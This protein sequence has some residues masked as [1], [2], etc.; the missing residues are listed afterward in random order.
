MR[1]TDYMAIEAKND[2]KILEKLISQNEFYILKCASKATHHFITK[3]EDE[4]SVALMAFHQAVEN[5]QLDK[6]S[7]LSFAALV[8]RRRIIDYMKNQDRFTHEISVDPII[9]DT[10]PEEETEDVAI[11]LAVAEQVSKTTGNEIKSEIEE[12]NLLLASYGFSFFDLTQCSPHAQKTK[13]ACAQ[14]INY[15]LSNPLLINDMKAS[16][17]LP[18]KI[19]ENNVHVPRKILERHRKYIIAAIEILSGGY[20]NLAE[21]LRYIREG[22]AE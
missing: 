6:G 15:M 14:V 21:Y 11:H 8:I 2:Q 10:E 5:Y 9:F 4:W 1:E 22:N 20:P 18:L 16:K 12:A 3:S 13:K 19:M 17:Q 7:F